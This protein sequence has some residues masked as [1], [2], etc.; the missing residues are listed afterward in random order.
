MKIVEPAD[1]WGVDENGEAI[2]PR[3]WQTECLPIILS[4]YRKPNP[5]RGVIHAVTGSGK[6]L[7]I[8]ETCACIQC[9]GNECI[10]VSTS[11]QKLVRQI[12]ATIKQRLENTDEFMAEPKVG[13]YY[14]RAKDTQQKVIVCCNN[15]MG[16]LADA[17]QKAGRT[18]V[19][20]ICDELHKS[21]NRTMLNAYSKLMPRYALGLS[22]TPFRPSEKQGI[23]NFDEV[24]YK[25]GIADALS[26]KTVIVPWEVVNWEGPETDR[27]T[28]CLSMILEQQGGYGLCNSDNIADAMQFAEQLKAKNYPCE[29]VHSELPDTENDRILDGLKS[30]QYKVVVY[31]DLLSEGVDLPICRYL[32]LRRVVGSR[33]RFIQELGRG[34]RY[35]KDKITGEEKTH[36][37]VLDPHQ[38]IDQFSL[39][40]QAV[41][42]GDFDPDEAAEEEDEGSRLER[43]LQQEC[44]QIIRHLT[45]V[46]AGKEP[47]S[48]TALATYLSQLVSVF[49]VFKLIEKKIAA[50]DW[51]RQP[52]SQKQLDAMKNMTW[53][54]KRNVVPQIHQTAL[55][56]LADGFGAVMNRGMCSDLLSIQMSLA[57]KKQWPQFSQLDKI[58]REGLQ[59]HEK[60]KLGGGLT[61]TPVPPPPQAGKSAATQPN[62]IVQAMLFEDMGVPRK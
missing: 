51:R 10:V 6:A 60:K 36:L 13:A 42:S 59:R 24:I 19:Y 28:A 47:A 33:N 21:E 40:Y 58:A 11:R 15:S 17:L 45:A 46:K 48:S 39:D 62:K 3:R 53:S 49:D 31:V 54:I 43:T 12:M 27:D 4:H 61:P 16:E 9:E 22:A 37:T 5:S 29:V 1:G 7:M 35:Y 8:A 34:I 25:Y 18:C 14:T 26:D 56:A 41:L 52:A 30:G 50:K 57:E 2:T 38:L 20:F 32:C 23:S 44:F 55:G